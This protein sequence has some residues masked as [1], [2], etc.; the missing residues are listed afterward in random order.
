MTKVEEMPADLR[1]EDV[2]GS[3]T[4]EV[5]HFLQEEAFKGNRD[6]VLVNWNE[7]T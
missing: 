4:E 7:S 1:Q 5:M 2:S 6:I 3:H